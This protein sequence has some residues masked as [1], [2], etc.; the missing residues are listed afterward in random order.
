MKK[1]I[2]T[3]AILAL[4][5]VFLS[6]CNNLGSSGENHRFAVAPESISKDYFEISAR[7]SRKTPSEYSYGISDNYHF[8]WKAYGGTAYHRLYFLRQTHDKA[9]YR[10]LI[11]TIREAR[12]AQFLLWLNARDQ[13]LVKATLRLVFLILQ[14]QG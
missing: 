2:N 7:A 13:L 8:N 10:M 11:K 6:A 14:H 12:V 9:V 1:I 3:L 4:F 5:M